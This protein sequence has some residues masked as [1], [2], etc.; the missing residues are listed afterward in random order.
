MDRY[1]DT[2]RKGLN[3]GFRKHG[4]N[5]NKTDGAHI[6]SHRVAKGVKE[7]TPGRP[8]TKGKSDLVRAMN[9]DSNIRIKSQYGNRV[10]DERRDIRIVDAFKNKT[11]ITEKTTANRAKQA[12]KAAIS[13]D[14]KTMQDIG[15]KMG[16]MT[17]H[18]GKQGRPKKVK[19]L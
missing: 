2:T 16:E 8:V 15:A 1:R 7:S 11:H 18:A 9:H 4:S 17:V 3:Q 12:Y 6:L 10:L 13:S 14:N 19:N 5:Q